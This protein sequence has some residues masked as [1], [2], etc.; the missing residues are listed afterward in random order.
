MKRQELRN[1]V[2]GVLAV[3]GGL[4]L[5]G[6]SATWA[7]TTNAEEAAVADTSSTNTSTKSLR[8]PQCRFIFRAGLLEPGGPTTGVGE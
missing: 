1:I 7:Q 3:L 6:A 8:S 4:E 2:N 5:C